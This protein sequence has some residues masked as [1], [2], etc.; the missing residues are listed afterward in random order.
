MGSF[1]SERN[2]CSKTAI[3]CTPICF[4]ITIGEV[5]CFILTTG[6]CLAHFDSGGLCKVCGFGCFVKAIHRNGETLVQHLAQLLQFVDGVGGKHTVLVGRTIEDERCIAAHSFEIHLEEAFGALH[7]FAIVPEPS[8]TGC[9]GVTFAGIP[10][11]A[12]DVAFFAH[13]G[14]RQVV[15]HGPVGV[16]GIT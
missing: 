1:P 8:R 3:V 13:H 6:A 15:G 2:R 14:F 5:G 12:V 11:P 4:L 10:E 7:R 9:L 16:A